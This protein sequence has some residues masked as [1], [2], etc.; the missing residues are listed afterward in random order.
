MSAKQPMKYWRIIDAGDA[1]YTKA[2]TRAEAL[3][4]IRG[5][6]SSYLFSLDSGSIKRINRR[7]YELARD[8]V[9]AEDPGKLGTTFLVWFGVDDDFLAVDRRSLYELSDGYYD[10]RRLIQANESYIKRCEPQVER[11]LV[12]MSQHPQLK[13]IAFNLGDLGGRWLASELLGTEPANVSGYEG[14][15]YRLP[16]LKLRAEEYRTELAKRDSVEL[17]LVEMSL[18]GPRGK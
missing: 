12:K 3:W 16:R 15:K 18:K 4:Q 6:S 11:A 5:D 2:P 17:E 7:Q 1:I 14:A 13:S 8:V 10:S 9:Q